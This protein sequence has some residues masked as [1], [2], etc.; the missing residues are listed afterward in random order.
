MTNSLNRYSMFS[1]TD[2]DEEKEPAVRRARVHAQRRTPRRPWISAALFDA[3]TQ[4]TENSEAD[5][6]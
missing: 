3:V 2:G 1:D 5:H 4:T 6:V